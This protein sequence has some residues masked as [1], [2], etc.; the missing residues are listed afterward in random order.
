MP[1]RL[2]RETSPYLLQH[3]HNPVDWYPWGQEALTRAQAED[4]PIIVSIGYSAC[5]WCHVM[6]RESFEDPALAALMNEHF[7]NIKV[8]REERPDVDQLYMEA[9]QAMGQQGG[10]PLNAFLLSDGQPFYAGTYFPPAQ[11]RELLQNV[12]RAYDQHRDKLTAS[13]TELTTRL[14]RGE[15]E[16][17]ALRATGDAWTP[18]LLDAVWDGLFAKLDPVR[19]G[20][21]Y[22]PK[23]PMPSLPTFWLRYGHVRA[24]TDHGQAAARHAR[25]TLDAMARG[26]IYDQVGGGFARYSVDADWHVPHFEKMLYDNGQLVSL[27]AE[28][29]TATQSEE[30]ADVVRQTI[31]FVTRELTSPEGA[32]YAALDADSEG[33]EGKF[34]VWSRKE[35]D[36]VLGQEATLLAAYYDISE[37]GN[38]EAGHSIPRRQLADADF[39]TQHGLT[40]AELRVRVA[41]TQEKL[42][43]A[44]AS[45]VRPGLDDK[46]LMGWNGLMLKGLADAYRALGVAAW[47]DLAERNALFLVENLHQNGQ[48]HRT[49]KNGEP[50]L[51]AYLEDYALLAQ[52]LLSLYQ[53]TFQEKWLRT[54]EAL[55]QYACDHFFDADEGLFFFTDNTAEALIARKKEIFDNVIP[56]SNSVMAHNLHDLGRLLDRPDWRDLADRM[57]RRL[58]EA[59]RT[60]GQYLAHWATLYARRTFPLAEVAIVGPEC[61]AR[62]AELEQHYHP[63]KLLAGAEQITALPWLQQRQPPAG[64]T[65]LYVCYEGA[66]QLPVAEVSQA[67]ALLKNS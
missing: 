34:Y 25:R 43:A 60:D 53:A 31:A 17:Y 15:G 28:A 39:A 62:R 46:V 11:W 16:K 12:V 10:W 51:S 13:A 32:F 18:T 24:D 22:A 66:C 61:H 50:R 36:A 23:F 27:Y 5:H 54:A 57:L 44:R 55:T 45:R 33:E 7:I 29:Y 30:Y 20:L 41:A 67:Q 26:G 65:L 47:R 48:W 56:A 8:D 40:V 21:H 59:L 35:W 3:A 2:A 1:N 6:E 63:H 58:T 42:L 19:G 4:K 38:W 37:G 9:V 64:Q 49:W 52:G 14:R